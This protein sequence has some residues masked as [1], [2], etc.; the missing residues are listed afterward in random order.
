LRRKTGCR[1]RESV[2]AAER[3][4][5]CERER[6]VF[7]GERAADR[8]RERDRGVFVKGVFVKERE[9]GELL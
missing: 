5:D 8:E 1:G 6:E 4:A 3:E 2:F 9:R 7:A